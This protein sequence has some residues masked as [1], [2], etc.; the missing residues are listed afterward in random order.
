MRKKPFVQGRRFYLGG[1]RKQNGGFFMSPALGIGVSFVKKL[2]GGRRKC[3]RR[4]RRW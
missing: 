2:F 1:R 3:K 4:R